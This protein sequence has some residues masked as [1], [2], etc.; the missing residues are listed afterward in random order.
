MIKAIKCKETQK[1]YEMG[2]SRKLPKE[3]QQQAYRKLLML[4][5]AVSID[6]LRLP[7]ANHLEKSSGSREG[8]YSIRS[9]D[10]WRVCFVRRDNDT[11][12]VAIV[13]YH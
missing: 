9:N 10:P 4:G 12:E 13:D 1:I 5:N 11:Y 8:Q 2:M 3:I 7:P 6:D